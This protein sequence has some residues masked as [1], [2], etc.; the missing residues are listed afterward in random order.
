MS[1]LA[2][3][4]SY[5]GRWAGLYDLV[6]SAPVVDGVRE[7]AIRECRLSPGDTVVEMGCGTGA[8]LPSLR[9]AVGPD[10]TVVGV[11][12]VPEMLQRARKRVQDNDW[13]NVHVALADATRPPLADDLDP[14]AVLATFVVGMLPDSGGAVR[15]WLDLLAPGGRLVLLNAS[16]HPSPLAAPANLLF[17]GFVRLNAAGDRTTADSP[18]RRLEAKV[19][20]AREALRAETADATEQRL[21]LGYLRLNAATRPSGES[22]D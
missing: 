5:Y 17:R 19:D 14:D 16:R 10:G 18:T 8:N 1:G 20:A 2:G 12:L 22:R 11:D 13:A 7:R 21:G 4:R 9:A 6:A 3:T 15:D